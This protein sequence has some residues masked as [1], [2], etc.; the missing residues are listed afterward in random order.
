MFASSSFFV[1]QAVLQFR[2]YQTARGLHRPL[3]NAVQDNQAGIEE[4]NSS[5]KSLMVDNGRS[6]IDLKSDQSRLIQPPKDAQKGTVY[7]SIGGV[8]A[9]ATG[10]SQDE[11]STLQ[12]G[13]R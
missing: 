12:V 4:S 3:S 7:G 6:L 10:C 11:H 2:R 9:A 5:S 1:I 13:G 8:V